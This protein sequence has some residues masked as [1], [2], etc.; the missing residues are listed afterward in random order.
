THQLADTQP[1]AIERLEHGPVANAQRRIDWHGIQQPDY[2]FDSEQSRQ[3]PG[4]LWITK[5]RRRIG[6]YDPG[7]ARKPEERSQTG[8]S[9]GNRAW[10]VATPREP[11]CIAPEPSR[12]DGCRINLITQSLAQIAA[13]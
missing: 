12:V 4:L 10:G 11:R 13:I 2:R 1:A 7:S 3:P 6:L 5:S 9:P 8:Q